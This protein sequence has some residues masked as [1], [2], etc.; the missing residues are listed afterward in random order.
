MM[1]DFIAQYYLVILISVVF[2]LFVII[3]YLAD[4]MKKKEAAANMIDPEETSHIDIAEVGA[5]D[6]SLIEPVNNELAA[7]SEPE[8]IEEVAINIPEA[9]QQ[10][11]ILDEPVETLGDNK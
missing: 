7:V 4:R 5:S 9:E 8:A 10:N 3:G 6:T 2:I 11:Q 1:P